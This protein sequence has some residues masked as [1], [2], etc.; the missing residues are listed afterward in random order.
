M[1]TP[2]CNTFF[3]GVPAAFLEGVGGAEMGI[4]V[5]DVSLSTSQ[6]A[7]WLV[8]LERAVVL[9]CDV[10]IQVFDSHFSP[11]NGKA[12]LTYG[13]ADPD[14]GVLQINSTTLT[15]RLK[16]N[17]STEYSFTI[18]AT[19]AK[20]LSTPDA[21]CPGFKCKN[22]ACIPK[23][24]LC[25]TVDNCFDLSDESPNGT[26]H[27]KGLWP[28]QGENW[29]VLASVLGAAVVFGITAACCRHIR[30]KR[31]DSFDDLYELNEGPYVHKY[32]G[33]ECDPFPKIGFQTE[34]HHFFPLCY[35]ND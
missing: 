24:L 12:L 17:N 30:S 21:A 25:D 13:C 32:G 34:L 20:R 28:F 5:C 6:H 9:D 3:R 27:C 14:P 10:Y 8:R 7:V 23:S 1:R 35:R 4:G 11:S 22:G 26:S 33:C 29:G 18:V 2:A 15:V 31:K 16:H 19:S